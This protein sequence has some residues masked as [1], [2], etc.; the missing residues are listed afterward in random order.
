MWLVARDLRA[1]R[2]FYAE[3]LGLPLWREEPDVALHFGAGGALLTIRRATGES[4]PASPVRLVFTVR[5][6]I[7]ALCDELGRRGVSLEAPL[8]DRPLGRSAMFRDPDGTELWVCR[9][10]ETETQFH[11]WRTRHRSRD[12]RVP[13]QRRVKVRR[14]EAKRPPAYRPRHPAN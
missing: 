13:V 6:G 5:E 2:V 4:P 10:S 11:A 1:S 9:P 14:H 8:A 12:R 7:E 3:T